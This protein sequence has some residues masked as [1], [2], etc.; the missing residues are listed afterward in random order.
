MAEIF[1][2]DQKYTLIDARRK[3]YELKEKYR[4]L[5]DIEA[6]CVIITDQSD[7]EFLSG[8]AK[9]QPD[10]YKEPFKKFFMTKQK[11]GQFWH[12]SIYVEGY[13]NINKV[14]NL[15]PIKMEFKNWKLA[16]FRKP[17][18]W[19]IQSVRDSIMGRNI[20]CEITKLPISLEDM[21]VDHFEPDFK[22]LV[23]RF[24]NSKNM[25]LDDVKYN[26]KFE[27]DDL[28]LCEEWSNYHCDEANIRPIHKLENMKRTEYYSENELEYMIT[29]PKVIYVVSKSEKKKGSWYFA[30]KK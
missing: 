10:K 26:S 8:I 1:I 30:K 21:Q 11:R 16:A 13:A 24:L 12:D 3:W 27:I 20:E 7:L 6:N 18:N 17:V 22:E 4:P 14:L 15:G 29:P 5:L 25:R 23:N 19:Y 2:N 9:L 28:E